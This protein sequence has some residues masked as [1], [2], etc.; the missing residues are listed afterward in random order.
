M[1]QARYTEVLYNLLKNNRTKELIDNAMST[2]PM[3]IPQNNTTYTLI[4]TREQLNNKIL[5]HYKYREIGFETVGRFLEE[6][7]IAL[8]EIMPYY[9]QLYK[10]ADIMNDIIDPFGN[11]DIVET[12]EEQRQDTSRGSTS[13]TSNTEMSTNSTTDTSSSVTNT[14]KNIK[15]LTPQGE[16]SITAQNIDTVSYADEV[17]WN[18]DTSSSTGNSEGESTSTG[19]TTNSGDDERQSSGTT[20]HTFTKVGNQGVNTYAHDM[21]ELRE[22][23]LNIDQQIIRDPRIQE[24]FMLVY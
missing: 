12:F 8:E 19:S 20:T 24:L 7:K 5:N 1:I 4:S 21:K 6:L 22:I 10:S 14:D 15:S 11:V 9:Y 13:E 18:K 2:Y 23:F 17:N 3:Y 16:L